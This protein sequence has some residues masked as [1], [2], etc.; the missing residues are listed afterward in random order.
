MQKK[1]NG[2]FGRRGVFSPAK[3]RY[4]IHFDN[5]K[6]QPLWVKADNFIVMAA[7]T[8]VFKST[9][10]KKGDQKKGGGT[11]D[12]SNATFSVGGDNGG[13]KKTKKKRKKKKK[14]AGE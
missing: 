14:K 2:R 10:E 1:L 3:G 4:L 7:A 13:E 9:Y 6:P 8:P 5:G 12:W 11:N